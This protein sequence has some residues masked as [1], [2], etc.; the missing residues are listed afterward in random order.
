MSKQRTNG[1]FAIQVH[2]LIKTYLYYATVRCKQHATNAVH[3]PQ[4]ENN[5]GFY[6]KGLSLK[7]IGKMTKEPD[8]LSY[9]KQKT[10]QHDT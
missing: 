8:E 6:F 5:P 10:F 1:A 9:Y 3:I 2:I 7:L 4:V